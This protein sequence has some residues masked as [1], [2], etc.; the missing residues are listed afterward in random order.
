MYPIG[1]RDGCRVDVL[2]HRNDRSNAAP[3]R[4]QPAEKSAAFCRRQVLLAQAKPAAT[5]LKHAFGDL[6]ERQPGLTAIGNDEQRRDRQ[7]H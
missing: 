4:H 3:E 6:L 5:S 7:S 1:I 2:V